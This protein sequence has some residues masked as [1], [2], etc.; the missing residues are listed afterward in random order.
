MH[1]LNGNINKKCKNNRDRYVL[2]Q[3]CVYF[4][5]ILLGSS[6]DIKSVK[7]KNSSHFHFKLNNRAIPPL[8]DI[9]HTYTIPKI[10]PKKLIKLSFEYEECLNLTL[11]PEKIVQMST[12][13]SYSEVIDT[14]FKLSSKKFNFKASKNDL[15]KSNVQ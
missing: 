10:I 4:N 12:T 3:G 5:N 11:L 7:E 9:R 6:K 15:F 13:T 8:N 1:S 14:S 2:Y